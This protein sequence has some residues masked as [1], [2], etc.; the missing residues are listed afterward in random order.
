MEFINYAIDLGTTNSLIAKHHKGSVQ[1]FKN[2]KGFRETLPSVVAFRKTGILIGDKAKELKDRD[3]QNVFSSFKRKMGT[4]ERF[5]VE[6]T[7]EHID[8]IRLSTYVLNELKTFVRDEQPRSVVI[9][10]ASA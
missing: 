9:T 8:P 1:L 6:Q 7:Q 10:F 4:D 2:P 5:F 3:P